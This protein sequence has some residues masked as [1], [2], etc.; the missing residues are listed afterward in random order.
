M[1]KPWQD[2]SGDLSPEKSIALALAILPAL[3]I[4]T[5]AALGWLAPRVLANATH[6]AGDWAIRLLWLT[7]TVTPLRRILD[8]P[9]LILARRI[10]GLASFAYALLHVGLYVANLRFNLPLALSEIVQRIYLGIGLVGVI[11]L[12]ILAAHSGDRAIQRLGSE[13]WRHLHRS[14]YLIAIVALT[15]FFIQSRLDVTEPLVLTGLYLWLMGWRWLDSR[16]LSH[17]AGLAALAIA[18]GL[19]TLLIEAAWYAG[20]NAAP[21]LDVILA[22]V[23]FAFEIRPMWIVL[24][25]TLSAAA[26]Q[27]LRGRPPRSAAAS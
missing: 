2:R 12:A 20:V 23:D 16:R 5:Q 9:R 3:W 27:R 24:A 26:A 18:S 15:H 6:Q 21:V 14:I 4:A 13:A 10:L 7:L 22:N 11:G 1:P 17:A 25:A 19:C 8:W